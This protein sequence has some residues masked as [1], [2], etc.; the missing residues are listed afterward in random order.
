MFPLSVS[1]FFSGLGK[2]NANTFAEGDPAIN[3]TMFIALTDVNVTYTPFNLSLVN[4]HVAA[5]NIYQAG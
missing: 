3:G 1:N 4:P 2:N 5:M